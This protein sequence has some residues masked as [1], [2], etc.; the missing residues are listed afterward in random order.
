[1]LSLV[2][3]KVYLYEFINELQEVTVE[4]V[5]FEMTQVL[6]GFNEKLR[7][8]FVHLYFPF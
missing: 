5:L 8:R 7:E 6:L 4:R 2:H 1:M 3:V